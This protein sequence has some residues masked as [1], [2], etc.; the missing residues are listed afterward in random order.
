MYGTKT[1]PDVQDNTELQCLDWMQKN[2]GYFFGYL[3]NMKSKNASR[4]NGYIINSSADN[5]KLDSLKAPFITE[6][7]SVDQ[8]VLPSMVLFLD[9]K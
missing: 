4:Y 1:F 6:A 2:N 8:Q 3:S 5:K 7:G 9:T